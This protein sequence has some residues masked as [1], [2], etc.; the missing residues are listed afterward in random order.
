M[1]LAGDRRDAQHHYFPWRATDWRH[2]V[3]GFSLIGIPTAAIIVALIGWL[4]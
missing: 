2:V 4:G 1:R 3:I